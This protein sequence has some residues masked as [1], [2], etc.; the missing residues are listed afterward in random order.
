MSNPRCRPGWCDCGPLDLLLQRQRVCTSW[1]LC[2]QRVYRGRDERESPSKACHR[3]G[4]CRK[5]ILAT[6]HTSSP[7]WGSTVHVHSVYCK[8]FCLLWR[9]E[10]FVAMY[11]C[12]SSRY[13]I[14]V[15]VKC[16]KQLQSFLLLGIWHS[17]SGTLSY[18]LLVI[19][20]TLF[21]SKQS[22]IFVFKEPL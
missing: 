6:M 8:L 18:D 19:T 11:F 15:H 4:A 14:H 10:T 2:E 1:L 12:K 13:T 7:L 22:V 3:K 17:Y 16:V 20:H 21:W 5:K 9:L